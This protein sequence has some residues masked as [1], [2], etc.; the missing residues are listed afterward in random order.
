[1]T[2][3]TVEKERFTVSTEGMAQLHRG[4]PVWQLVKELVANAWDERASCR[5]DVERQDDFPRWQPANP[6]EQRPGRW[7]YYV[8][9]DGPFNSVHEA[10]RG[11]GV[12]QA[13][14]DRHLYWHRWDRL[15]KRHQEAIDRR[16]V[17]PAERQRPPEAAPRGVAIFTVEDDG[18]GFADVADAWTLWGYTPKRG[19]PD[20]RG[21]FNMGEKEII[22]VA[23]WA[24]VETVDATIH[25]PEGGGR[26]YEPNQRTRGTLVTVALDMT[27]EEVDET[28]EVLRR[29]L[30]PKGAEYSV[31]GHDVPYR[32]PLVVT[33]RRLATVIQDSPA[34]PIRNTH[35][36]ADIAVIEKDGDDLEDWYF[37]ETPPRLHRPSYLYEMGVPVQ[38]IDC[39]YDVDVGQKI[40]LPPNRDTV[41]DSYL[42]DIYSAV[43]EVTAEALPDIRASEAWVKAGVEDEA[44]PDE[45]VKTVMVK[46]LGPKAVLW[47]SDGQANERAY[48]EGYEIV[49]AQ[50]LSEA[51]R[52]RFAKVGLE[53]ASSVFGA[54][55]DEEEVEPT[56]A[57]LQV[58]EYACW[59]AEKLL[60]HDITVSFF[61]SQKGNV[62]ADYG[63]RR[64]RFNVAKLNGTWW[65]DPPAERHTDLIIHELAH[66]GPSDRPHSGDYVHLLSALG[67]KAAHLAIK[68]PWW[69][70]E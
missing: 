66:D 40:P 6:A 36:V 59:L 21:R 44:T 4:R 70:I 12:A 49:R 62:A 2:V 68:Q 34:D 17:D 57:M 19:R 10:L 5:V 32:E 54:D 18:P 31:Q 3:E 45:T 9:G 28:M 38:P 29:F 11:L 1:M 56:A 60:G 53:H 8:A 50:S 42:Q 69:R 15:P 26:L 58:K 24:K 65:E 41:R 48:E 30:P 67:A 64:L 13:E 35:R 61:R 55:K 27:E 46:K 51:E 20:V 25:F 47:S 16:E 7:S 23:R 33:S 52:A 22:S 39:P 63:G 14:I 43:L 37:P